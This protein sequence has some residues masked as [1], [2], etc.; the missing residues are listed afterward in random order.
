MLSPGGQQEVARLSSHT[1]MSNNNIMHQE[2]VL[3]LQA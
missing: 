1:V 3:E 2:L